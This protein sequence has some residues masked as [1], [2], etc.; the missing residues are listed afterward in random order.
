MK[1]RQITELELKK[2]KDF[3]EKN[4]ET[5]RQTILKFFDEEKIV[6][7]NEAYRDV[8]AY[9]SKFLSTD[10]SIY[11]LIH[12]Q[13]KEIK[14]YDLMMGLKDKFY[15]IYWGRKSFAEDAKQFLEKLL[16]D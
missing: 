8:A 2:F 14:S 4:R 6:Q 10:D 15:W 1:N 7:W 12:V 3:L 11:S 16:H 13:C 5:C 9:I